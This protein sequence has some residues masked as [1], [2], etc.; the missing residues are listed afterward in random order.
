MCAYGPL[1]QQVF[2]QPLC[3]HIILLVMSVK[4]YTSMPLKVVFLSFINGSTPNV[5]LTRKKHGRH[6]LTQILFS[7]EN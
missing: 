3:T 5:G 2:S 6:T 4:L 1:W 7:S